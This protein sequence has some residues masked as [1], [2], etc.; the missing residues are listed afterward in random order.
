MAVTTARRTLDLDSY[1]GTVRLLTGGAVTKSQA[2]S[3]ARTNTGAR[4]L[5]IFANCKNT[6]G[7]VREIW[8]TFP[9]QRHF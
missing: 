2:M 8:Y 3:T 6:A 9:Q 1:R 5:A 7:R 4:P